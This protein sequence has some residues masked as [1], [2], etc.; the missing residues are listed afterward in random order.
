MLLDVRGLG[1][2]DVRVV[3][4]VACLAPLARLEVALDVVGSGSP[5]HRSTRRRTALGDSSSRADLDLTAPGAGLRA[6]ALDELLEA[7]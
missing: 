2:G 1:A 7:L 4:G 5:S 3:G 6:A